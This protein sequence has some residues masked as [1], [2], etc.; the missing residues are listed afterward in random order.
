M[1][2]TELLTVLQRSDAAV[3]AAL[4]ALYARQTGDEQQ[5]DA[6]RHRNAMGFNATDAAFLSSLARQVGIGRRLSREQLAAAR[7]ALPKYARQLLASGVAWESLGAGQKRNADEE[8]LALETLALELNEA[9][10]QRVEPGRVPSPQL[11]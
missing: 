9:D 2:R 5:G 1:D 10:R 3:R 4:T 8:L 6:T 11:H 7:R